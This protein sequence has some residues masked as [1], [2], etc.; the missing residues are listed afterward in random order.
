[1]NP[2]QIAVTAAGSAALIAGSFLWAAGQS[3]S[4]AESLT[5]E[6]RDSAPVAVTDGGRSGPSAGDALVFRGPLSNGGRIS[7]RATI[8]GQ[9]DALFDAVIKVAGRGTIV[10]AGRLDF[11]KADQGRLAVVGGTGD[12]VG[13][14]GSVDVT[15]GKREVITFV[16]SLG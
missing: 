12:F 4:A 6:F 1:M 8:T 16:V 2:S 10:A 3:A 14:A 5:F 15:S 7:A 13:A 9:R 11:Q